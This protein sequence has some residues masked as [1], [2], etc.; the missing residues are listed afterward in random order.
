MPRCVVDDSAQNPGQAALSVKNLAKDRVTESFSRT[1]FLVSLFTPGALD[2]KQLLRYMKFLRDL[3]HSGVVPPPD[4]AF[5]PRRSANHF[6]STAPEAA[7]ALIYATS[8][9]KN[10][11]CE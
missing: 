6:T 7:K 5:E 2:R 9:L 10:C 4:G 1:E 8:E 3:N 11:R